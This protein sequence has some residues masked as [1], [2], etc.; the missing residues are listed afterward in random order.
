MSD[1]VRVCYLYFGNFKRGELGTQLV[2]AVR[3]ESAFCVLGKHL[4]RPRTSRTSGGG[5]WTPLARFGLVLLVVWWTVRFEKTSKNALLLFLRISC[6][7][8]K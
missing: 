7:I 3:V 8:E 5:L 4:S 2:E 6:L 1:S